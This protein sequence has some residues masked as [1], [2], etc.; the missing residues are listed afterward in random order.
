MAKLD[1]T[2]NEL[3]S[4]AHACRIAASASDKDAAAQES[5]SVKAIFASSAKSYRDMADM[6]MAVAKAATAQS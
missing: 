4:L 3:L 1:L 5:V 6:L 2:P